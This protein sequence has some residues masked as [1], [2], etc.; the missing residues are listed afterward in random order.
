M[1]LKEVQ[2]PSGN[3]LMVDAAPFKD[4]RRLY[5]AIGGEFLQVNLFDKDDWSNT[6][7]NVL[8]AGASSL[9][10]E[11]ALE[12][13]LKRCTYNGL[14]ITEETFEPVAARE[15]YFDI[16]VEVTKENVGPFTKSLFAQFKLLMGLTSKFPALQSAEMMSGSSPTSDLAMRD[17]GV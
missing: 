6:V 12:P 3:V 4:A 5:Q 10:I 1:A 16:C 8:C 11:K 7:K 14:K 2:L 17:T 13:C 15:D 9:A